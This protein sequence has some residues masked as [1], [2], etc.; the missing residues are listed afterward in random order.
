[1][2]AATTLVA[3]GCYNGEAKPGPNDGS[4]LDFA[5]TQTIVVDDTGIHPDVASA[6]VETAI[7]VVN[8]GTKDH[9][10]TSDSI[11]T[12]TLHPGESTTVFLTAVGTIELHDRA[13]PVH[14]ARIEVS[15][16]R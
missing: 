7:A 14:T 13:D 8:R 5:I 16:A 15:T 2:L 12:G 6:H 10:V 3:T 1:M 11:D 4:G 9:A